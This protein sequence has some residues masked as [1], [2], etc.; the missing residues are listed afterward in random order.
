MKLKALI[1]ALLC[2]PFIAAAQRHFG[3]PYSSWVSVESSYH[4]GKKLRAMLDVGLPAN[5]VGYVVRLT[6]SKKITPMP[7]TL[8]SCLKDVNPETLTS[9]QVA[10]CGAHHENSDIN[11]FIFTDS[12]DAYYF[13]KYLDEHMQPA[14]YSLYAT[15]N[16]CF[17]VTGCIDRYITFGFD[18][19]KAITGIKVWVE[20]VP[21]IN[22][23]AP[24]PIVPHSLGHNGLLKAPHPALVRH[25]QSGGSPPV[26]ATV[27]DPT[28][29]KSTS[30]KGGYN[31]TITN[32]T[33]Q[34]LNYSLSTDNQSWTT[35][36]LQP[37]AT[38]ARTFAEQPVYFRILTGSKY[39]TH[40]LVPNRKYS[41]V[42]NGNREWDIQ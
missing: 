28:P 23:K 1:L 18:D 30:A 9:A 12:R 38:E 7:Q 39:N 40:S 16:A 2:I 5:T 33:T 8:S 21:V 13:Y 15:S 31:Y 42:V 32:T 14:C 26:P 37:G 11:C 27:P 20:I 3:Q 6:L 29:A 35:Y 17:Y 4:M 34:A 22:G 25:S 19:Y 41:L 24:A 10:N 36:S